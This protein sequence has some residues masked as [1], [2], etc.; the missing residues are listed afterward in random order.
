MPVRFDPSIAGKAPV[1][2]DA[3]NVDILASATV[4]LVNKSAL[5][6]ARENVNGVASV[7][8]VPKFVIDIPVPASTL[9]PSKTV[10]VPVVPC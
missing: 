6:L 3:V 9:A 10:T 4:P 7:F 2:F 8:P 1:N 5:W